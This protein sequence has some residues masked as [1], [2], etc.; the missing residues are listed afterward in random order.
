M[1]SDE[2]FKTIIFWLITHQPFYEKLC[3]HVFKY[4]DV[5]WCEL[6]KQFF[7]N[8]RIQSS[9]KRQKFIKFIQET[10]SKKYAQFHKLKIIKPTLIEKKQ[11]DGTIVKSFLI[12]DYIHAS[13]EYIFLLYCQIRNQIYYESCSMIH[14]QKVD[15]TS[16]IRQLITE[17]VSH[18]SFEFVCFFI[19]DFL[20]HILLTI[21]STIQKSKQKIH[22]FQQQTKT[23]IVYFLQMYNTCFNQ[24][25]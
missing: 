5:L 15:V 3:V 21:P 24:L 25:H 16:F 7:K 11:S 6:H 12:E 18:E 10:S 1:F 13:V 19:F 20:I 9:K 8:N 4:F 2:K 23:Q 22:L 17:I 14:I